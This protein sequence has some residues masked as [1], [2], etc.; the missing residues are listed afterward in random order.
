MQQSHL[1]TQ[2]SSGGLRVLLR[3]EQG[4]RWLGTILRDTL[5]I[6]RHEQKHY[7]RAIGGYGLNSELLRD[8]KRFPFRL[9][10]LTVQRADGRKENHR[11]T[12][13]TWL[14]QGTRWMHFQNACESQYILPLSII[15]GGVPKPASVAQPV[16]QSLFMESVP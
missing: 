16:Q 2:H 11:I 14:A 7:F 8:Q 12:R 3:S 1:F 5:Q 4:E 13:D 10:E 9:I 15:R 6:F